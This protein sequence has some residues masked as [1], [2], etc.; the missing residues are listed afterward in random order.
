MVTRLGTNIDSNT[1]KKLVDSMPNR[2]LDV[3][4]SR[5]RNGKY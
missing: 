4:K 1:I 3:Q 2:I 5:G